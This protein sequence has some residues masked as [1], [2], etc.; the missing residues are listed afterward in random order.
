MNIKPVVIALIIS[1]NKVLLI[2][3][4]KEECRGLWF[5]PGGRVEENENIAEAMIRE[6]K[7]EAG[8]EVSIDGLFYFDETDIKYTGERYTRYRFC[9]L[10]ST[11]DFSEKLFEDE[12]SIRSKW[13]PVGEIDTYELRS[14]FVKDM[15]AHYIASKN[16]IPA[17]CQIRV[18]C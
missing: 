7:E 11:T 10:C 8:V 13:I 6:V 3:E 18:S 2:Q 17:K 9:F 15:I 5:L 12:H 14:P 4:S 1:Y 16:S